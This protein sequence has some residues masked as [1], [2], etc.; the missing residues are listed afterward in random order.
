MFDFFWNWLDPKI[1]R[2]ECWVNRRVVEP[3]KMDIDLDKVKKGEVRKNDMF[4]KTVPGRDGQEIYGPF[5]TNLTGAELVGYLRGP[6]VVEA[7]SLYL[8][9]GQHWWRHRVD[10]TTEDFMLHAFH[11]MEEFFTYAHADTDLYWECVLRTQAMLGEK[12]K[13][14][15]PQLNITEISNYVLQSKNDAPA[16]KIAE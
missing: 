1:L 12:K 15:Q 3:D 7:F 11:D 2:M 5:L 16:A 4:H 14:Q 6:G 10:G 8:K 13:V 9:D